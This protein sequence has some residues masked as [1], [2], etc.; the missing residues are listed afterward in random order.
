MAAES[1]ERKRERRLSS[2]KGAALPEPRLDSSVNN[3]RGDV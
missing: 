3:S 1:N 2:V